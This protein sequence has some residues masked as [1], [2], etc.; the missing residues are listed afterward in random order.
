MSISQLNKIKVVRLYKKLKTVEALKTHHYVNKK[1]KD[2]D[3][4]ISPKLL[5]HLALGNFFHPAV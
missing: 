3:Q 4:M 2:T 5:N 1:W